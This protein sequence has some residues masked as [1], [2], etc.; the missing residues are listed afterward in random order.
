M[1][2][3]ACRRTLTVC[4]STVQWKAF[5]GYEQFY[6]QLVAALRDGCPPP[7]DPDDAVITLRIIEA[8]LLSARSHTVVPV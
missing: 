7:V 8:A 4:I 2:G 6:R 5:E 1:P 3:A